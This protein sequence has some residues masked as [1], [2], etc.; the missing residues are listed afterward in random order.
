LKRGKRT[1]MFIF[2]VP[3]ALCVTGFPPFSEMPAQPIDFPHN[4]HAGAKKIPCQYCHTGARRSPVAMIPSVD[5]CIGCHKIIAAD[6]A[7]IQKIKGY[8]ERGEP[9]P[10][11]RIFTLPDFAF[12]NHAPHIQA[13]V[14][15]QMCHGPIE[16]V[17]RFRQRPAIEMG[18]CLKCHREKNVSVDCYI[19]HR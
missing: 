3:L 5:R 4:V 10:W 7:E 18:W 14:K 8:Y 11:V 6:K 12:F 13:Q 9:I 19:C 15:C 1:W 2:I 17:D 16:T